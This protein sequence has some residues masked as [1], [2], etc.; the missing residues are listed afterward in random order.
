VCLPLATTGV[1]PEVFGRTRH[2]TAFNA[3]ITVNVLGY[4][5]LCVLTGIG[6]PNAAT[7]FLNTMTLCWSGVPTSITRYVCMQ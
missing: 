2:G 7:I 3:T 5:M 1:L 6:D 4:L